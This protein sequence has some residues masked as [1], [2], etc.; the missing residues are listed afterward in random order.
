MFQILQMDEEAWNGL[1]DLNEKGQG[2]ETE[3]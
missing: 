2:N 1:V 3:N